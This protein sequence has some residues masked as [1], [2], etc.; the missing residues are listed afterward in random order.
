MFL[1]ENPLIFQYNIYIYITIVRHRYKSQNPHRS[2]KPQKPQNPKATQEPKATKAT[3][4]K[5]HR[6][7]KP[8]KPKATKA[9]KARSHKSHRSQKPPK[10]P[11]HYKQKKHLLYCK[12][13]ITLKVTLR[14]CLLFLDSACSVREA[15]AS[16]APCRTSETVI[17]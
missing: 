7:Q 6:S 15:L 2:Q 5:S 10:P 8:Q 17:S 9:T 3:K 13:R 1:L 11:N 12:K 16:L 4:A 14:H